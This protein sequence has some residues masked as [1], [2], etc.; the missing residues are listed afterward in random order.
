MRGY[1]CSDTYAVAE[2]VSTMGG[3]LYGGRGQLNIQI[4][5]I[6]GGVWTAAAGSE[7]G[8]YIPFRT[9]TELGLDP[10]DIASALDLETEHVGKQKYLHI[11]G[12]GC[13]GRP[14]SVTPCTGN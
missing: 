4:Y 1:R 6:R 3:V 7:G 10:E 11:H 12:L 2:T 14:P 8:S 13:G 5:I 9:L